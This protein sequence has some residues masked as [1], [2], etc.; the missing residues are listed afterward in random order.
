M[1]GIEKIQ[2]ADNEI[3]GRHEILNKCHVKFHVYISFQIFSTPKRGIRESNTLSP[4][5]DLIY[6][7]QDSVCFNNLFQRNKVLL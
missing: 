4:L 7:V 6:I 3:K 5:M 2:Y 1:N